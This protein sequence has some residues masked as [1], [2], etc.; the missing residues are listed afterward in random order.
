MGQGASSLTNAEKR[1]E[2]VVD[3]YDLRRPKV[4]HGQVQVFHLDDG[5]AHDLIRIGAQSASTPFQGSMETERNSGLLWAFGGIWCSADVTYDGDEDPGEKV[6][7]LVVALEGEDER[8]AD[9][10]DA[11]DSEAARERADERVDDDIV[12]LVL[13][14]EE[15]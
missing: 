15:K 4:H 1:K 13:V 7:K 2:D 14:S 6:E 12:L 9:P 5:C 3:R 10:L 8:S 11:H